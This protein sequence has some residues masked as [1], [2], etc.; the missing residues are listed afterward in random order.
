MLPPV[1][2]SDWPVAEHIVWDAFTTVA[3]WRGYG[4]LEHEGVRYGQKAHSLRRFLDLPGRTGERFAL[5]LAIHPGEERDLRALREHGWE[6]LDPVAVAGTPNAY[7]A[8]VAGSKGELGIAKEGYVVSRS[9][10][11]SDRSA[12]YLA[13]GRPVLAQDTGFGEALPTGAGLFAFAD[14]EGAAGAIEAL[15][16]DYG[17]HARAARAIAEE[18][19]DSDRVLSRLLRELELA[20]ARGRGA[21][22]LSAAELTGGLNGLPVRSARRRPSA[23]RSSYPIVELDVELQDGRT[24]AL[25]VKDL[26]RDAIVERARGA[27]LDFL[28]DPLREIEVYRDLL[29]PAALGTPAFHGSRG[30]LLYLERVGGIELYQVGELELWQQALRWLARLH[31][32]FG[33][34]A[35]PRLVRYDR[36]FYELW[37]ARAG[38]ELPGYD[39]LVDRLAA[40]PV[41]LVHGDFYA[42]NVLLAGERV[43][44]IDWELAGA[45][46]GVLDVAA[47]TMGWPDEQRAVLADAYRRARAEPPPQREFL[48]DLDHASLHLAVQWLGWSEG[49]APPPEHARDWHAEIERFGARVL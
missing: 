32:R 30:T 45:G 19:L 16:S 7:R 26:A 3:N 36:S 17:R 15:R 40:L 12:C 14:T 37:P 48:A 43:C 20:P 34:V 8:F 41:T 44:A 42:S 29:G 24:L 9:G 33:G 49:W 22:E 5:A 39:A 13:C 18:F 1:V 47:I 31:D 25:V 23:Y 28:A 2:L 21:H 10:W 11:F 35:H 4:T 27:K 38:V 46:A 6:L